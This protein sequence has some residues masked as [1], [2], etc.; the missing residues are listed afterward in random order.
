MGRFDRRE[1]NVRS[2][3]VDGT[4]RRL[5]REGGRIFDLVETNKTVLPHTVVRGGMGA[6]GEGTKT[7]GNEFARKSEALTNKGWTFT[8]WVYSAPMEGRTEE[9]GCMGVAPVEGKKFVKDGYEAF[10]LLCSTTGTQTPYPHT[11]PLYP[12]LHH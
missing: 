1:D 11:Y 3:R 9:E 6:M 2:G 8:D 4:D 7:C 10:I 12:L 5:G